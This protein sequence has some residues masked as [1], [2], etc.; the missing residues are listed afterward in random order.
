[1]WSGRWAGTN[2]AAIDFPRITVF[3]ICVAFQRS[4]GSP[5]TPVRTFATSST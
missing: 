2:I 5:V 3:I 4:A 1:M